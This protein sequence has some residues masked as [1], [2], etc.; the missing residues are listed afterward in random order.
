ML[1]AGNL[2]FSNPAMGLESPLPSPH[3]PITKGKSVA[4]GQGGQWRSAG[5]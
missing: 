3:F 4:Y 5:L 1:P 2:T